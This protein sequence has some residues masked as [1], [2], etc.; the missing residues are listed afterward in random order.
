MKAAFEMA[1]SIAAMSPVAVQMTKRSLVYSRDHTVDESLEHIVSVA[2]PPGKPRMN[3]WRLMLELFK[4]FCFVSLL[5]FM[6]SGSTSERR[7]YESRYGC[8]N[9]EPST[10]IF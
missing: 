2:S 8:C 9:Q 5:G 1:K 4:S 3:T 10:N 6:E 7:S